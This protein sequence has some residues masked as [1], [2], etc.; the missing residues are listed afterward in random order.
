MTRLNYDGVQELRNADRYILSQVQIRFTDGG[1]LSLKPNTVFKIE[2]YMFNAKSDN[3]EKAFF[4]L[5]KGGLRTVIGAIGKVNR[6][7]YEIRT[8]NATIG[9]RGTAYSANQTATTLNVSV[10]EGAFSLT[11]LMM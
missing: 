6:Q 1:F 11:H 3:N 7:N 10:S 4:R 2:A 5:V 9:I 8:S